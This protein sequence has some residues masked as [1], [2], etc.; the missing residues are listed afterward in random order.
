MFQNHYQCP[1]CDYAWSD[2]WPSQV[3]DDCPSCGLRHIS[4]AS[5]GD[6]EGEEPD[7]D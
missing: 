3:D 4:P 2:T 6:A 7:L 5:S 1:R